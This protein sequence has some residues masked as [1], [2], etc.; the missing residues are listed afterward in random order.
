MAD[1]RLEPDLSDLLRL[2]AKLAKL[3]LAMLTPIRITAAY[4]G[5]HFI[6]RADDSAHSTGRNLGIKSG[7]LQLGMAQQDLDHADIYPVFQQMGG[8]AMA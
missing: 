2:M 6:E 8:K 1:Q 3:S 4:R 7:V 5:Q